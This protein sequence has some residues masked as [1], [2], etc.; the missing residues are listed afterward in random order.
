MNNQISY[1]INESQTVGKCRNIMC[2]AVSSLQHGLAY[3]HVEYC[4]SPNTQQ[5]LDEH[6]GLHLECVQCIFCLVTWCQGWLSKCPHDIVICQA[7]EQEEPLAVRF[8]HLVSLLR[9]LWHDKKQKLTTAWP[10]RH[11]QLMTWLRFLSGKWIEK[12]IPCDVLLRFVLMDD[13]LGLRG[14]QKSRHLDIDTD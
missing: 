9:W 4:Y 11:K 12:L 6:D 8:Q 14:F 7:S 10:H 5:I 1:I 2:Y 13:L 3:Q